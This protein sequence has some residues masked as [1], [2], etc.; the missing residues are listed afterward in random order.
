MRVLWLSPV[1]CTW[2]DTPKMETGHWIT[3]LYELLKTDPSIELGSASYITEH[4]G[5]SPTEFPLLGK[6]TIIQ[7]VLGATSLNLRSASEKLRRAIAEFK[8]D[9]LHLHGAE[10]EIAAALVQLMP[11]KVPYVVSLQGIV[12]SLNRQPYGDVSPANLILA[13]SIWDAARAFP[14]LRANFRRK[15]R[16]RVEKIVLT[17][18]TAV[19]GRT[20][21]DR[22]YYASLTPRGF[23]CNIGEILRPPFY[24][25]KWSHDGIQ[26]H[27]IIVCSRLTLQK[28]IKTVLEA[29]EQ[30]CGRYPDALLSIA[31]ELNAGAECRIIRRS[32]RNPSVATRIKWLGKLGGEEIAA[33]LARSNVY[34]NPSFIE[35]SS[36]SIGEALLVGVPV[37]ATYTGGT[38]TILAEGAFGKLAP[39]G[40]PFS[41]A[42]RIGEVFENGF[43]ASNLA[44]RARLRAVEIYNP[45]VIADSVKAAY[46]RSL[47]QFKQDLPPKV[48]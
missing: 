6:R 26:K 21:F 34:V 18:A 42:A 47:A 35:N 48:A 17:N 40:C 41:L 12:A 24:R 3:G 9:L 20:T 4:A 10:G 32:I 25:T 23:Y 15:A 43:E 1:R 30:L 16:M 28:G 31:G 13:Q 5:L 45:S 7:R 33:Q 46:R 2:R 14:S 38:P 37:V 44:A 22:A 39:V 27:S 8:P 11:L 19:F 29:F 36:N